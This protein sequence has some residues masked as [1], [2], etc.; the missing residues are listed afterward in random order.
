LNVD[1]RTVSEAGRKQAQEH[2]DRKAVARSDGRHRNQ[3]AVQQL[4]AFVGLN[5]PELSHAMVLP[6]ADRSYP[7]L[8]SHLTHAIVSPLLFSFVNVA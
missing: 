4:H 7:V 8:D 2:T 3:L 5:D 6:D 1:D